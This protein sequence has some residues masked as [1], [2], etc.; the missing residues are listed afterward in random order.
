MQ[1]TVSAIKLSARDAVIISPNRMVFLQDASDAE[2]RTEAR[3]EKLLAISRDAEKKDREKIVE[4]SGRSV[5]SFMQTFDCNLRCIYC[6]SKGG[7]KKDTLN[8]AIAKEIID[9]TKEEEGN[10]SVDIHLVGGGEPLLKMD[11]V[12][13]IV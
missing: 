6:Y 11:V 8:P 12:E 2:L 4:E 1:Q 9:R 5:L 7:D 3:E 10:E 13:E